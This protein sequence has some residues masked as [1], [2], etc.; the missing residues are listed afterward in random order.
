MAS[1]KPQAVASTQEMANGTHER[2]SDFH[3]TLLAMA[4]HDLRQPLQVILSSLSKLARCNMQDPALECIHHS[5]MRSD[6]WLN[7]SII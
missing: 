3:A 7:I 2:E 6:G 5:E 1:Q 4:G